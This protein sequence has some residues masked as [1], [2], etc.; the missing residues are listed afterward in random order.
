[1][2][3]TTFRKVGGSVMMAI[4]PA[5]L[6]ALNIQPGDSAVLMAVDGQLVACPT[7]KEI[8]RRSKYLL[9]DLLDETDYPLDDSEREWV[10]APVKGREIL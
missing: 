9:S 1:M 3:N 8:R 10:D 4:P 5:L 6:E 7:P 2:Y